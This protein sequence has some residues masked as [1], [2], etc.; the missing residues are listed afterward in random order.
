MGEDIHNW[1]PLS[2]E[3]TVELMSGLSVPWWIA[4]GWAI[5]LFLGRQ[6]RAHGDTDV[7][8]RRDDQLEVQKYLS[9]WD[10]HKTQQ[11]GLK[12]WPA[13]EFQKRPFDDIWCRRRADSPWSLQFMLLDTDGD[14]WVFKRDES[15]R[16]SLGGLG[17][18]T[19][20][21]VPYIAPEIQLLYKAKPEI[22]DKDQS[23]FDLAAPCMC[24]GAQAWLVRCLEKRFREGHV[25]STSLREAMA[26]Q[27]GRG[28]AEDRAPQP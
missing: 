7:L 18:W 15:I 26:Q 20:S 19:S 12:P 25:W 6:T 3:E 5:D 4:G 14:Q 27:A 9:D 24:H 1:D 23:D 13:G 8:V 11:P 28:G 2:V 10:L 17:R 16:G 22:L 21:G